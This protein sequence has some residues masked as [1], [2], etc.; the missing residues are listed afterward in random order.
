[1]P[2]TPTAKEKSGILFPPAGWVRVFKDDAFLR[3]CYA[4]SINFALDNW[5]LLPLC[6]PQWIDL[7]DSV[8]LDYWLIG[9]ISDWVNVEANCGTV[10]SKFSVL[11]VVKDWTALHISYASHFTQFLIRKPERFLI[12]NRH[13]QNRID[14]NKFL[15]C[16]IEQKQVSS[17]LLIPVCGFTRFV[18]TL[19]HS[20]Q[21]G[22]HH[23]QVE[24]GEGYI[25]H[26]KSFSQRTGRPSVLPEIAGNCTKSLR[27]QHWFAKILLSIALYRP[28]PFLWEKADGREAEAFFF[29]RIVRF[30]VRKTFAS[31]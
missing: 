22:N 24:E 20:L 18:F 19:R 25:I 10:Q 4:R 5:A 17:H 15:F 1:M 30:S 21:S 29:D 26:D 11:P 2:L 23:G 3:W 9:W 6:W 8:F 28:F 12:A 7:E 14:R 27:D 16:A 31:P 13:Y